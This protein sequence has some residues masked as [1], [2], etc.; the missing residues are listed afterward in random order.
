[1]KLNKFLFVLLSFFFLS[2]LVLAEEEPILIERFRTDFVKGVY[3][4]GSYSRSSLFANGS[5]TIQSQTAEKVTINQ[6]GMDG[7]KVGSSQLKDTE[8]VLYME[9]YGEYLY[10]FTANYDYYYF[11]QLNNN[12]EIVN[13]L[14][15]FGNGSNLYS[16]GLVSDGEKL[17]AFTED[18]IILRL[19]HYYTGTFDGKYKQGYAN[20][21]YISYDF[22]K[23]EHSYDTTLESENYRNYFSKNSRNRVYYYD[24]EIGARDSYVSR[25]NYENYTVASGRTE[26]MIYNADELNDRDAVLGVFDSQGTIWRIKNEDYVQFSNTKV[27]DDKIV[28]VGARS[29]DQNSKHLLS[30]ILVYSMEGELLE[31]IEINKNI[32][33]IS[34]NDE[35]LTVSISDVDG[36]CG[37]DKYNDQSDYKYAPSDTG[38]DVLTSYRVYTLSNKMPI[39]EDKEVSILPENPNT[40]S[41]SVLSL[42]ILGLASVAI[43]FISHKKVEF[44]K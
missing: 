8:R 44:L 27:F 2:G 29:Y 32:T 9:A 11:Y 38:C 7:K 16:N 40:F 20:Y 35:S 17:F 39:E 1:M 12:M 25:D 18:Y 33:Y 3:N 43:Y 26:D 28:T 34:E 19:E 21:Y 15:F 37:N 36:I 41:F 30:D 22:S 10:V 14:R 4:K 42:I 24:S 23:F 6:Y 5:A 31:T 13:T